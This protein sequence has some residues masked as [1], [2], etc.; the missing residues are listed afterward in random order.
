MPLDSSQFKQAKNP[1]PESGAE[2]KPESKSIASAGQV[3][4]QKLG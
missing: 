3:A 4:S 1:P 2:D